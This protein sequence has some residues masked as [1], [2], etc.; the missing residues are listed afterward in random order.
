MAERIAIVGV[1]QTE[2]K[3]RWPEISQVEMVNLA[4]KRALENAQL[5]VRDVDAVIIGNMELFEGNYQVDMWMAEGDGA[6]MKPGMKVQ[7]G[8]STGSTVAT[9]VFDHAATGLFNAVLGI[10]FEKQ[11][12]G[13]SDASLRSISE[14]TFF[15]IGGGGRGAGPPAAELAL[16]MLQRGAV[17]EDQIAKLRVKSSECA[18]RNPHAHLRKKLTVEEV[19]NSRYLIPPL[20]LWHLCPTSVG[21]CAII[22]A[23]EERAKRISPN[24]AWIVDW[25]TVHGGTQPPM[26]HFAISLAKGPLGPIWAFGVEQAS[27]KL[28]KRN[29]ITNPRKEF[30]VVEVYDMSSWFEAECYERMHLCERNRSG[31]LVD[32]G[33]TA[34]DGDIPVNPSGGVVCTN[35]IGASA[36]LRIAEAAIQIRGEGGERQVPNVKTALAVT[37]GGD[38]YS[39]AVLLKKSLV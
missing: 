14:D 4:V 8:G 33:A 6:Y 39:S 16:D 20:R 31:K 30:D 37:A 23:P 36:M 17:T 9:T 12:E 3:S 29:G 10:G 5:T 7:T 15:D 19:V 34:L 13:S 27:L 21:A 18:S 25:V 1:G 38:N 26:G 32:E 11:D 22:V 35:A 24:P 2:F 28:Y